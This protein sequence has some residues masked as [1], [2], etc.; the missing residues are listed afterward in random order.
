MKRLYEDAFTASS[1]PPSTATCW[2]RDD[3]V[4]EIRFQ[5][6]LH[7]ECARLCTPT[8]PWSPWIKRWQP[9]L[10]NVY[11]TV[12]ALFEGMTPAHDLLAT[13]ERLHNKHGDMMDMMNIPHPNDVQRLVELDR[14]VPVTM[15]PAR[16]PWFELLLQTMTTMGNR[17]STPVY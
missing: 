10:V 5:K 13:Y 2:R 12:I 17:A 3:M 14:R 6:E 1:S 11:D 4:A 8:N 15:R 7:I 9:R 16:G